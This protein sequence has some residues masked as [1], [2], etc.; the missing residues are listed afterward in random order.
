MF[1]DIAAFSVVILLHRLREGPI[2]EAHIHVFMRE[3]PG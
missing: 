2:N 1:G 3:S